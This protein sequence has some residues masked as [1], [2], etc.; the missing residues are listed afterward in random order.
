MRKIW[1]GV[2]VVAVEGLVL[3]WLVGGQVW[4]W[5]SGGLIGP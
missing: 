3:A 1:L 4:D 5:L 2:M